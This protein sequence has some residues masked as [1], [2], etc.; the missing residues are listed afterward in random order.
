[1][2]AGTDGTVGFLVALAAS[3]A[4]QERYGAVANCYIERRDGAAGDRIRISRPSV[5]RVDV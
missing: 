2:P 5:D 3:K 4:A 1:V